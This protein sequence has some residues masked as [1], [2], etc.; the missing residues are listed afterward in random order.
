VRIELKVEVKLDQQEVLKVVK[1]LNLK[2]LMNLK[3]LH[4]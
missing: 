1:V 2:I 4:I 3:N